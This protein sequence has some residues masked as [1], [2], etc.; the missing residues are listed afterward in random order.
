MLTLDDIEMV[1]VL[2]E[3]GLTQ[4]KLASMY[5]VGVKTIRKILRREYKIKKIKS[6]IIEPRTKAG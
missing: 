6:D 4:K 2:Y 5:K 1:R 3:S